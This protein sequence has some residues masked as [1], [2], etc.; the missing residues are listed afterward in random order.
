MSEV[1][2]KTTNEVEWSGFQ[3]KSRTDDCKVRE[4]YR[5]NFGICKR[6][7]FFYG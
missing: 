3:T 7:S 5:W 2:S 1:R 6:P 4:S